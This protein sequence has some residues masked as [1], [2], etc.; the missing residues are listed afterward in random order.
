MHASLL[1]RSQE[2][3]FVNW[4][5]IE[6]R[7]EKLKHKNLIGK[8]TQISSENA[9]L[10]LTAGRHPGPGPQGVVVLPGGGRQTG[11]VQAELRV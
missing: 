3:L 1:S 10:S 8:W 2:F 5:K 11:G 9:R 4:R 7:V 6:I